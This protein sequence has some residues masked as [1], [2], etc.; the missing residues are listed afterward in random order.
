MLMNDAPIVICLIVAVCTICASGIRKMY[1]EIC[2][3]FLIIGFV[4][5]IL[6]TTWLWKQ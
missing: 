3:L 1:S 2:A 4:L 6:A 5:G